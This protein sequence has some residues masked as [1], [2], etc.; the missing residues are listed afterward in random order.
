MSS[1]A[2]QRDHRDRQRADRMRLR[3]RVTDHGFL[4]VSSPCTVLMIRHISVLVGSVAARA[5]LTPRPPHA[6]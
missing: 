6:R 5:D 2:G 1:D 4:A 3:A